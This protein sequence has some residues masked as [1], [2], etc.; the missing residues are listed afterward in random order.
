MYSEPIKL[1]IQVQP[2]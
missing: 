1:G 2:S